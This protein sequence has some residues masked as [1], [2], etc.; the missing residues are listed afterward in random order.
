MNISVRKFV[1]FLIG[2][3]VVVA[4]AVLLL[5]RSQPAP[6]PELIGPT[7]I[8]YA[9]T[10]E[11]ELLNGADSS[12][13][14]FF[15]T[16]S[17]GNFPGVGEVRIEFIA[18]RQP[19]EV[20]KGGIVVLTG[21]AEGFLK[22]KETAF[23]LFRNGF[24]VYLHDYRGQ[25]L[26]QRLTP[27]NAGVGHVET[28]GH[29]VEDLKRFIQTVVEPDSHPNLF[30]LAHSL[31][32]AITTLYLMDQGSM[33]DAAVLL[34]P[35]IAPRLTGWFNSPACWAIKSMDLH[36]NG[37]AWSSGP[38]D[39]SISFATNHHTHSKT[40]HDR[41]LELNAAHPMQKHGGPSVSWLTAACQAAHRFKVEILSIETP[42]LI[43]NSELDQVASSEAAV[44]FCRRLNSYENGDCDGYTVSGAFHELLFEKD[45]IRL[46]VLNTVLDFFAMRSVRNNR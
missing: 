30:F 46:P 39:D 22:Y 19:G 28:F 21:R 42:M 8:A 41:I 29:Y 2:C 9:L 16:G 44:A 12:I 6:F 35:L 3:F 4:A 37:Y 25:G 33:V 36:G 38:Y 5:P 32:G 13:A 34:S 45:E 17:R 24:S 26:S 23:D 40:R 31:G 18:F 1:K 11:N 10:T 27:S 43:L 15:N 14:S 7:R 20:S